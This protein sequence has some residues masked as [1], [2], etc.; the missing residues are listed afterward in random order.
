M[1]NGND[2]KYDD[3]LYLMV[4]NRKT[5]PAAPDY[6]GKMTISGETLNAL[7]EMANSGQ[8]VVLYGSAWVKSRN[9]GSTAM[10]VKLQPPMQFRAGQPQR[11]PQQAQYAPQP[12]MQQR[13]PQQYA[14][15]QQPQGGQYGMRPQPQLQ[16]RQP[17]QGA[18]VSRFPQQPGMTQRGVV[19]APPP[20][21]QQQRAPWD[22]QQGD[23]LPAGWQGEMDPPNGKPPF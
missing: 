14:P 18:T 2:K 9:D 17:Q 21:Q 16:V 5:S 23:D 6:T 15:Q 3:S 12:Q 11:Q 20:T 13:V 7:I 10:S 1:N 4:N 8:D 22:E 19:R